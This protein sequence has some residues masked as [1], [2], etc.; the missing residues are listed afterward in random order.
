MCKILLVSSFP[1]FK[2]SAT[3]ATFLSVVKANMTAMT[4]S[5]GFKC[6]PQ[7]FW[8]VQF[9]CSIY[10]SGF[11]TYSWWILDDHVASSLMA[12]SL[13]SKW[14]IFPLFVTYWLDFNDSSQWKLENQKPQVTSKCPTWSQIS[15]RIDNLKCFWKLRLV[16]PDDY[17]HQ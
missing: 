16:N 17:I 14:G 7:I 15:M 1:F 12:A 10:C 2:M 5:H 6:V 8:S 13:W 4:I 9:K 3:W 11:S